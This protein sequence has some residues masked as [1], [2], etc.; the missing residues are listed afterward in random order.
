ML[1]AAQPPGLVPGDSARHLLRDL[2]EL[3]SVGALHGTVRQGFR[4]VRANIS[5]VLRSLWD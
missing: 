3:K 4:Q 5:Q 2:A 1:L